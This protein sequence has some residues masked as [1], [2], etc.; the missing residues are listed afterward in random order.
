MGER[1]SNCGA[2]VPR[3]TGQHAQTP[4]AGVVECPNCGARVTLRKPGSP[5]D[6]SPESSGIPRASETRGGEESGEDYFAGE[7]TVEGVMEEAREK[8][9]E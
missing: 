7:E 8:D 1:C 4:S 3:D 6:A 9:G 2:E 5:P